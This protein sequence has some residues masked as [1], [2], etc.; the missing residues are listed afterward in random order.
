MLCH[1]R[2]TMPTKLTITTHDRQLIFDL[3]ESK[4]MKAG[5]KLDKPGGV[6]LTVGPV[7]IRKAVGIPEVL[8]FVIEAAKN[9]EFSLFAAWLA[10]KCRDREVTQVTIGKS[11]LAEFTEGDI[12]AILEE[13]VPR[14]GK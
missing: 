12:T 14:E 8:T 6:R 11:V 2:R 13:E 5:E 3:I 1:T 4:A 7:S 9:V 10:S